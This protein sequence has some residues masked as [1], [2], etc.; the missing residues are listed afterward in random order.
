MNVL[1]TGSSGLIGKAV[2]RVLGEAGHKVKP[3][4]RAEGYD[5]MSFPSCQYAVD[6]VDAVI[7]LAGI[8]GT[9]ELFDEIHKAIDI[10]ISGAV[11]VMSA[12]AA[13]GAHYIGITMLDVFPS[14]YTATKVS[15]SRFATA[16]HYNQD[17]PVTQVRAFNAFGAD[18]H[19]GPGHPRKIIPAFSVEGWQNVPMK[20]WGDGEQTVD[21][22]HVNDIARVFLDAL[23]APGKNE[24]IDAGSGV[25]LTV[26]EVADFVL[27]ITGS[28]AGVEHLPMRRGEIPTNIVSTGE[29]WKYLTFTPSFDRL[30]LM[31][32][33]LA[34]KDW[35]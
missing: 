5:I 16:F 9:D 2:V 29:G 10:N 35:A 23:Q 27:E 8:L 28:T 25:S 15:A 14:I 4:D 30:E 3:F 34:Y 11:N 24:T 19:H 1:V 17:M 21:L 18:Q 22:I 13:E 32:T 7:H 26:N 20:I 31:K 33:I 6:N 12:C